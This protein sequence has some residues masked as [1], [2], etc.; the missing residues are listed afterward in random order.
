MSGEHEAAKKTLMKA[1]E[2][3][4]DYADG[5]YNLGLLLAITGDFQ[6]STEAY[7]KAIELQPD[8]TEAYV[9]IG[10]AHSLK[11]NTDSLAAIEAFRKA[12]DLNPDHSFAREN[13]DRLLNNRKPRSP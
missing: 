13:L 8:H 6:A 3:Q 11:N 4:P 12:L 7:R 1:I 2:L 5:H 10:L 9:G